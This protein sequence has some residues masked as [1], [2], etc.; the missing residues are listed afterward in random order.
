MGASSSS[1]IYVNHDENMTG[2]G[3][4]PEGCVAELLLRLNPSE[5]CRLA[6]LNR[7]FRGAAGS[8]FVWEAKLPENYQYMMEKAIHEVGAAK[9]PASKKRIYARL[10][11]PNPIDGGSKVFWLD[12]HSGRICMSISAKA[13]T[14]TGIDERRYWNYI[15]T[16]ESRFRSVAYLQQIWWLEIAGEIEFRFPPGEYCLYYRLHLGRALRRLG[17]RVC[18]PEHIHGWDIKPVRFQLSTSDG[19]QAHSKCYLDEPGSW[20]NY[21]VGDFVVGKSNEL[22]KVKFSMIQIDCTHT[23][24]GLCVDSVL[25]LPKHHSSF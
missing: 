3:D 23:K 8:D 20:I 10:C 2:L 14:I 1:E 19:Q 17:R 6:R 22:M 13:M 9:F 25:I 18:S 15:P 12:K 21:H 16:E 4:L 24:G 11:R 5:I 7:A